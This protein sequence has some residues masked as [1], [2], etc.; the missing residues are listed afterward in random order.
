[1]RLFFMFVVVVFCSC[2]V[3]FFFE[4]LF[5]RVGAPV[6]VGGLVRLVFMFVV[7]VFC[8]CRVQFFFERVRAPVVAAWSFLLVRFC[9]GALVRRLVMVRWCASSPCS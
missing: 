6:G 7:V 5:R 4:F 8:S 1:M 9:S 3:Q 2:R